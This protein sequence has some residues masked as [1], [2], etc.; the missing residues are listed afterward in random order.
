MRAGLRED[1]LDSRVP[2]VVYRLEGFG[3][4]KAREDVELTRWRTKKPLLCALSQPNRPARAR[5]D[6]VVRDRAET[7]DHLYRS[8]FDAPRVEP[9]RVDHGA[10]G[11]VVRRKRRPEVDGA[12]RYRVD[13]GGVRPE[14]RL[15]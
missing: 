1:P 14:E 5:D 12:N 15:R 8:K 11:R 4:K 9:L 7:S 6:A 3:A 13:H 10:E 2:C